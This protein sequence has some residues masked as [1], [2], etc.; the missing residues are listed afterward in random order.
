MRGLEKHL[1][2]LEKGLLEALQHTQMTDALRDAMGYSL[3]AASKRLRPTILLE[4]YMLKRTDDETA[5]PFALAL[6]MIH[7]YSLIH[8]D[9]PA[10]DND[11]FRRGQP[12]SHKTF[13]EAAAILAGDALLTL[14]F[15]VMLTACEGKADVRSHV[16]A[17]R[18]IAGRSG[19]TGMVGGQMTE[20]SPASRVMT[21]ETQMEI[22]KQKTASL[23]M[24]A[25]E[26]GLTLAGADDK[27]VHAGKTYGYHFGM[28]FQLTDD[29]LDLQKDMKRFGTKTEA[30]RTDEQ[31]SLLS[32]TTREDWLFNARMHTNLAE[33]ALDVFGASGIFLKTLAKEALVRVQ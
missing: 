23:F 33:Q 12:S 8:D 24:A 13:G 6:E 29:L 10:M 20:I 7:T 9:L 11:D 31:G 28:A 27:E 18:I 25:M 4:A 1:P 15:E 30:A 19:V 14:A 2:R 3:L 22:Y 5:L 21:R 26:C 17:A 32:E 16:R